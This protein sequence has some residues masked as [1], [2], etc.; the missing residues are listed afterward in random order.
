MKE[1]LIGLSVL[2]VF[3]FFAG[4]GI[5]LFPVFLVMFWLLRIVLGFAL[6]LAAI[7]LLGK[8]VILVWEKIK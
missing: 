7:W 2:I 1:F 8:L 3:F 4:I 5:L 6:V